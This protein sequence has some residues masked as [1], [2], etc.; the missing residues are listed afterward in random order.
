M[1]AET[2]WALRAHL[3]QVQLAD[4]AEAGDLIGRSEAEPGVATL[5]MAEACLSR[6]DV[7]KGLLAA[8]DGIT[9]PSL[10]ARFPT[11]RWQIWRRLPKKGK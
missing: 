7:A 11:R 4:L 9:P 6:A 8:L 10:G 2:A 5:A 1:N 3:N